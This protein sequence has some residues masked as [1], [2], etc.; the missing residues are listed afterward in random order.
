MATA[1]GLAARALAATLAVVA[2]SLSSAQPAQ[3]A[4]SAQPAQPVQPAQPAPEAEPSPRQGVI[5]SGG[6]GIGAFSFQLDGEG[7]E[8]GY[9]GVAYVVALGGFLSPRTAIG[10]ELAGIRARESNQFGDEFTIFHRQLGAW[11]RYWATDRVW[12]Q[13]GVASGRAGAQSRS[14]FD[15]V[16]VKGLSLCGAVGYEIGG[17]NQWAI[18]VQVRGTVTDYRDD[19]E[20]VDAGNLSS[21]A[22]ALLASFSWF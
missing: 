8:E 16:S 20:L 7:L 12:L 4:P 21:R 3:P 10:V 11:A 19:N 22:A 9:E 2:P 6:L 18:D 5:F 17:N 1:H 15:D 14:D 13:G